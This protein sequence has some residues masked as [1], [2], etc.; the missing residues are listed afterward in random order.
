M[1]T[2][3]G[4]SR[5][6]RQNAIALLTQEHREAK[7]LFRE[8]AKLQKKKEEADPDQKRELVQ[9][10]CLALTIHAQLEEELFYPAVRAELDDEDMLDEA[11]VEH[12]A[13]KQLIAELQS[14]QPDEPLYDARFTVLG[15]YVNHHIEEE[16]KQM[17]PKVKK[18]DLD[19]LEL[20]ETMMQRKTELQRDPAE[21]Q[22]GVRRRRAA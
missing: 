13:A 5:T 6:R 16:E 17:F 14:A 7:K 4:A 3:A 20:G 19:L 11:E 22:R 18:T 1:A 8:F 9:Q 12:M 10:A 15:E 2:R 21:L